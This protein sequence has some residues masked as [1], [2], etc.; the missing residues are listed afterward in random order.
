LRAAGAVLLLACLVVIAVRVWPSSL[1]TQTWNETQNALK[2]RDLDGAS[3]ALARYIQLR[4]DE[5]EAWFLSAQIARRRGEFEDAASRLEH[6]QQLGGVTPRTR[7]EWDLLRVQQGDLREIDVKLR[8]TIGP[9]HPD[10]ILVLEAL[11]KGYVK[12]E[13]LV[14]AAQACDLWISRQPEH[15]WPWVCRGRIHERTGKPDQAAADYR[16]ALTNAPEDHAA[17]LALGSVLLLQRK[18]GEAVEHFEY[19]LHA[20]PH[21]ST[22]LIGL[23]QCRVELGDSDEALRLLDRVSSPDAHRTDLFLRGKA[24]WMKGDAAVAEKWLRDAVHAAPDNAAALHLL[25][26]CLRQ[27]EQSAEADRFAERLTELQNDL[28]RLDELTRAVTA[29]P[30]EAGLRAE[31]GA[32]ALRLGQPA[33]ALRWLN[34]ALRSRGDHR[35]VHAALAD[36]YLQ[37][38]DQAAATTHRRLA[39]NP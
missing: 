34:S 35:V 10:A 18:A 19:V 33:E 15:P 32:I 21:D 27:R 23:A 28:R 13:R 17:H 12:V 11:A 29:R 30:D 26:Q 24:A 5:P 25:V 4:P 20:L 37:T 16:Q 1:A 6:C 38:G 31:A 8:E 3:A 14:D 36:Y 9:D 39:T 22:A 2:R 7:L